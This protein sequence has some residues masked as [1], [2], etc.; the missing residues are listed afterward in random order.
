MSGKNC[1]GRESVLVFSRAG[2]GKEGINHFFFCVLFSVSWSSRLGVFTYVSC[3]VMWVLVA[4]TVSAKFAG[5]QELIVSCEVRVACEANRVLPYVKCATLG[6]RYAS[7][8]DCCLCSVSRAFPPRPILRCLF[9]FLS[10]VALASNAEKPR[11]MGC[12][13]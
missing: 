5:K 8:V 4:W 10:R 9:L 3:R 12:A 1:A 2:Q 6:C 7:L 13:V 11:L